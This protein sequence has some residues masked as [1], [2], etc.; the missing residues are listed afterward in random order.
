MRHT[1]LAYCS[2]HLAIGLGVALYAVQRFF[3]VVQ[4]A[5]RKAGLFVVPRVRN[6]QPQATADAEDDLG[7]APQAR[8]PRRNPGAAIEES[9]RGVSLR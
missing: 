2:F 4:E 8:H 5:L 9:T 7:T 1:T 3:K 6:S